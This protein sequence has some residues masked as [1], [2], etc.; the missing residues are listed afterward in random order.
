MSAGVAC[1]KLLA[2]VAAGL[3]KPDQQTIVPPRCGQHS[4]DGP[5]AGQARLHVSMWQAASWRLVFGSTQAALFHLHLVQQK[6]VWFLKHILRCRAAEGMLA[7][8]PLGNIRNF[9]GKLGAELQ[10]MGCTTP[11]QVPAHLTAIFTYGCFL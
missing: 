7:D 11:G 5:T 1:N 2:K 10:S 6:R 9:G 3:H 4:P 8:M